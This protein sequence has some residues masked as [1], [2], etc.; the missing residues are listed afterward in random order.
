MLDLEDPLVFYT[1]AIREHKIMSLVPYLLLVHV[2]KF[3]VNCFSPLFAIV[4]VGIFTSL[5]ECLE[6]FRDRLGVIGH[7]IDDEV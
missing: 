3:L 1:L 4:F 6:F 5:V 7:Q 2:S